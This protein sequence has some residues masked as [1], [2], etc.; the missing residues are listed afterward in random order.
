MENE[1]IAIQAFPRSGSVM[2]RR[3][4]EQI[5]GVYTGS[6]KSAASNFDLVMMGMA[7][8]EH[9]PTTNQTWTCTTHYPWQPCGDRQVF[10]ARKQVCM[11]RNPLNV[12]TSLFNQIHTESHNLVVKDQV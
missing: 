4:I 5:T 3:F 7:G 8:E 6:D 10:H 2:L 9:I 12:I 1:S 11:V